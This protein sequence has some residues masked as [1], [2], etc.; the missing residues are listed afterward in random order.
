VFPLQLGWLIIPW[1]VCLREANLSIEL[2]RHSITLAKIMYAL[3][4]KEEKGFKMWFHK[5]PEHSTWLKIKL[6][7]LSIILYW[8]QNNFLLQ[9]QCGDGGCS[10]DGKNRT[11]T[12][13]TEP[14]VA[15]TDPVKEKIYRKFMYKPTCHTKYNLTGRWCLQQTQEALARPVEEMWWHSNCGILT[16]YMHVCDRTDCDIDT[17]EHEGHSLDVKPHGLGCAWQGTQTLSLQEGRGFQ[18]QPFPAIWQWLREF[19]TIMEGG[20]GLNPPYYLVEGYRLKNNVFLHSAAVCVY[21]Y[22]EKE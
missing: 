13:P 18:Q 6:L 15:I 16:C 3:L 9:F 8:S 1:F 22:V 5:L 4:P 20:Q 14:I 7:P 12:D 2:Y 21:I 11:E 19:S 10:R 17:W